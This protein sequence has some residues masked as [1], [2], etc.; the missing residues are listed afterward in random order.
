M[1]PVKFFMDAN[2]TTDS[3][4][5]YIELTA[6]TIS[7]MYDERCKFCLAYE[8]CTLVSSYCSG[9]TN[10]RACSREHFSGATRYDTCRARIRHRA[11]YH[12]HSVPHG[13]VFIRFLQSCV[14]VYWWNCAASVDATISDEGDKSGRRVFPY[15]ANVSA[16]SVSFEHSIRESFILILHISRQR[17][18]LQR[19]ISK[20]FTHQLI[21]N[22]IRINLYRCGPRRKFTKRH[23]NCCILV[24]L[25]RKTIRSKL[26]NTIRISMYF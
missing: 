6:T 26:Q 11:E 22:R 1:R 5:Q 15:P 7:N 4:N 21:R 16:T 23:K 20:F 25:Q 18:I 17:F 2:F 8:V 9:R 19:F 3:R 14:Q 24:F 12:N 10:W 13:R